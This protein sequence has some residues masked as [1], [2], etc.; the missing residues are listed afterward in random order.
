MDDHTDDY[1]YGNIEKVVFINDSIYTI[2]YDFV[3]EYDLAQDFEQVDM[4]DI[5]NRN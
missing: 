5:N 2:S 4:I 3:V 1:Y